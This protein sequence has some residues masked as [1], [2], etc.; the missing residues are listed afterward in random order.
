MSPASCTPCDWVRGRAYLVECTLWQSLML[1]AGDSLQSC[2]ICAL[3]RLFWPQLG[4]S[5]VWFDRGAQIS[6]PRI[7]RALLAYQLRALIRQRKQYF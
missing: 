1:H 6:E 2:V 7:A 5:S 4:A 3:S